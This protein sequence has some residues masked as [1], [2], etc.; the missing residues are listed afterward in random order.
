M[1][2][3]CNIILFVPIIFFLNSEDFHLYHVFN[4]SAKEINFRIGVYNKF[5][6]LW[7]PR[8]DLK[9]PSEFVNKV[10][11]HGDIIVVG[12]VTSAYYLDKPYINYI[13]FKTNRFMLMSRKEGKEEIWTGRPLV[14]NLIELFRLVPSDPNYSLWLIAGIKDYMPDSFG[15]SN[16]LMKISEMNNMV[17]TLKYEGIDGRI[18]VY[19]IKRK[20]TRPQ[21]LRLERSTSLRIRGN[22]ALRLDFQ[23][24]EDRKREIYTRV[25]ACKS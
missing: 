15:Y 20:E 22:S 21:R 14:Y 25:W 12:A 8:A 2:T 5:S 13:D 16:S 7:Y 17:A 1:K 10:Y 23:L 24:V 3:I 6:Q 4:V 9:S 11:K 18:G 19:E